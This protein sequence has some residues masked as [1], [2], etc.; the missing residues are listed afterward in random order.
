MLSVPK[1][2]NSGLERMC[3]KHPDYELAFYCMNKK[4]IMCQ[5]CANRDHPE[6]CCKPETFKCTMEK[7]K[8]QLEDDRVERKDLDRKN[9]AKCDMLS[10]ILAKS[11]SKEGPEKLFKLIDEV[12]HYA[13]TEV[14]RLSQMKGIESD[15][16]NLQASSVAEEQDINR[17][18][19]E[20]ENLK[21]AMMRAKLP[22]ELC[23]PFKNYRQLYEINR[24]LK[25]YL[26][27]WN[28]AGCISRIAEKKKEVD[29]RLKANQ[30]LYDKL[31]DATEK[32]KHV[33]EAIFCGVAPQEPASQVHV[34]PAPHEKEVR[35]KPRKESPTAKSPQ[36]KKWGDKA[37][38][39][40]PPV[41]P[42]V[43]SIVVPNVQHATAAK[44]E[45]KSSPSTGCPTSAVSSI[46]AAKSKYIEPV[47][48]DS[49]ICCI[50]KEATIYFYD[51]IGD[52][53]EIYTLDKSQLLPS[54]C[55]YTMRYGRILACGGNLEGSPLSDTY[56]IRFDPF[57]TRKLH[58]GLSTPR[59]DHTLVVAGHYV[60]CIGGTRKG[61][62]RLR[63]VEYLD[64]EHW[65]SAPDLP[66]AVAYAGAAYSSAAKAL[67]VF[68]G[69]TADGF[70]QNIY[71]LPTNELG[72]P[73]GTKWMDT[74]AKLDKK[75][76]NLV[77]VNAGESILVLGGDA[78]QNCCRFDPKTNKL[79]KEASLGL[80]ETKFQRNLAREVGDKP[81]VISSTFAL[82]VLN[83]GKWSIKNSK[84]WTGATISQAS[85]IGMSTSG[86]KLI[87]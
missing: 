14:L 58:C 27:A 53:N 31:F 55:E 87:P 13:K 48:V 34:P 4:L 78:K 39:Q 28:T 15:A 74:G 83:E 5:L 79:E 33:I 35:P 69:R 12:A 11:K 65:Q 41:I 42:A 56:E 50:H 36:T 59:S 16:N 7:V 2:D 44:E 25:S 23:V 24:K 49:K 54:K 22:K 84:T 21:E 6:A 64:G 43:S 71:R 52:K 32:Y 75:V 63:S 66:E 29:D 70:I 61:K 60:Y 85:C 77:A 68:G 73:E 82:Y 9:A 17:D 40:I 20:Y 8:R 3:P 26:D 67:Y 86:S 62:E 57:A 81:C 72:E 37:Q 38:P 45:E 46:S 1:E 80:D 76:H 18:L 47:N 30:A 19:S 51:I 10:Q